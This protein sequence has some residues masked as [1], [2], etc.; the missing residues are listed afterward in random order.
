MFFLLFWGLNISSIIWELLKPL[1]RT[2]NWSNQKRKSVK[3]QK[4]W[5]L[6]N[7]N[8]VM[9][10]LFF[11]WFWF[12]AEQRKN[13]FFPT[14]FSK[15]FCLYTK[16][17][18]I[19]FFEAILRIFYEN[20]YAIF[21]STAINKVSRCLPEKFRSEVQIEKLYCTRSILQLFVPNKVTERRVIKSGD[22]R[23]FLILFRQKLLTI[24]SNDL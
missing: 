3:S 10:I 2:I 21:I 23:K 17:F 4:V 22:P 20:F 15:S 24:N 18:A 12:L 6:L 5:V 1:I 19:E 9:K 14:L 8:I 7:E 11:F 16:I 13:I